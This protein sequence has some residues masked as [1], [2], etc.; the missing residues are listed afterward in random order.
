MSDETFRTLDE[1]ERQLSRQGQDDQAGAIRKEAAERVSVLS[2]AMAS[3]CALMQSGPDGDPL[4]TFTLV[5]ALRGVLEGIETAARDLR[6]AEPD[7]DNAAKALAAVRKGLF[8][9][10][11]REVLSGVVVGTPVNWVCV[12]ASAAMVQALRDLAELAGTHT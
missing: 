4:R 2:G 3:A 7:A 8:G 6:R 5:V 10:L 9:G 12:P 11:M 1:C